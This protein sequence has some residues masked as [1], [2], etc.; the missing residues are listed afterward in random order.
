VPS[1]AQASPS[2]LARS[3]Y[4]AVF[5]RRD[6]TVNVLVIGVDS[7][8]RE[9]VITRLAQAS[10]NFNTP[11]PAGVVSS[12][13]LLAMPVGI[14]IGRWTVIDL[15][16]PEATRMV[17]PGIAQQDAEQLEYL[18]PID[19]RSEASHFRGG[20][21]WWGP[22]DRLAIH[23][24]ER[25]PLG[26]NRFG[27]N[28]FVTFADGATGEATSVDIPDELTLLPFWAPDG[29]GILVESASEREV[30]RADGTLA[31]A[32][33]AVPETSCERFSEAGSDLDVVSGGPTACLSPDGSLVVRSSD[34]YEH[35][36]GSLTVQAT[37]DS[38][39][40]DGRFAG[41]LDTRASPPPAAGVLD[42]CDTGNS[43]PCELAP[44]T[45]SP[46]LTTPKMTFTLGEGWAGVRHD[47]DAFSLVNGG[48]VVSFARD[49][50]IRGVELEWPTDL[51]R[52]L[53]SFS[54]L[55]VAPAQEAGFGAHYPVVLIEVVAVEDAPGLL[56]LDEDSYNLSQGQKAAFIVLDIDGTIGIFIVA[57]DTT[58]AFEDSMAL[59]SRILARLDFEPAATQSP[60]PT[61]ESAVGLGRFPDLPTGALSEATGALFQAILDAAVEGGLP[62]ITAT[63]LAGDRGAW[64]GV[65][66]LTLQPPGSTGA[67]KRSRGTRARISSNAS[68]SARTLVSSSAFVMRSTRRMLSAFLCFDNHQ[69]ARHTMRA[70]CDPPVTPLQDQDDAERACH[71]PEAY[72]TDA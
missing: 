52:M 26:D 50:T 23:W 6:S 5:L 59:A 2:D 37:G 58:E 8:G 11:A 55:E 24:Y 27:R 41:W 44:G 49:V 14:G 18:Y 64:S 69:D 16:D 17:I 53:H 28:W 25:V 9:R 48:T 35:P 51:W 3:G 47:E 40:V 21:A 29:S 61:A 56:T 70:S 38:L 62:G 15:L 4:E 20:R 32:S 12:S 13:G 71:K 36:T 66:S 39:A 33:D 22:G 43:G 57:S 7:D 60:E 72:A 1:N 10:G 19:P 46:S 63:V 54:A 31:P 67:A 30:L 42:L 34:S 45:Y 65:A 68:R